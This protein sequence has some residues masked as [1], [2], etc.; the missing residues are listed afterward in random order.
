MKKFAFYLPQFHEIPENNRWWGKGF[1]EWTKVRNAKPLYKG[2]V[3]PKEPLNDNYY[4]LLDKSAVE[5]QTSLLHEYKVDGFV[6]YHYYFEGKLLLNKPAENLLKWR[7]IDQ[8][9]FFCW[10]NHTWNRAWEEKR[11]ILIEQTYGDESSWEHH[12]EYLLPFFRDARYEKVNNKPLFMLFESDFS[13]KKQMMAYFDKRCKD[14]GFEG[15]Y[16]IETY[17]AQRWPDDLLTFKNNKCDQ[18]EKIL[19]RESTAASSIYR[20]SNKFSPW[21]FGFKIKEILAKHGLSIGLKKFD[22]NKL[23][24][25]MINQEPKGNEFLHS[26]FFEWDNTPRHGIRGFVISPPDKDRFFRFIASIKNDDYLFI[27]AWNEW[28]EGM[29]LEP[30]KEKQYTYLEWLKEIDNNQVR[31]D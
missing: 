27:N 1:T 18:C 16:V 6:Y 19:F 22:G 17:K 9:F 15:I 13:Q 21:W 11:E 4:C 10:A 12:F 30:S 14:C 26:V 23:Y 7:E 5:W 8:P 31:G 2:H 24:D 20:I 29:M 28:A 3:Q 25:V